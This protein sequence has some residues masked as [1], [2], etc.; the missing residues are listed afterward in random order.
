MG[1]L[2]AAV[3][4]GILG[5]LWPK[6]GLPRGTIGTLW[7]ASLPFFNDL[8]GGFVVAEAGELTSQVRHYIDAP[9]LK[10]LRGTWSAWRRCQFYSDFQRVLV[11]AKTC[12]FCMS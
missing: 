10:P 8:G 9:I 3:H 1:A 5:T 11:I 7:K 4:L 12:I 6:V 2:P